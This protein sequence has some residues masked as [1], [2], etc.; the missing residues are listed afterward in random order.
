MHETQ[1]TT[2]LFGRATPQARVTGAVRIAQ[3]R[4]T[5][6]GCHHSGRIAN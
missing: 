5:L 1:K 4:G 6:L 3:N 2:I